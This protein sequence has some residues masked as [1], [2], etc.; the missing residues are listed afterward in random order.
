MAPLH[1]GKNIEK[2]WAEVW[3]CV[4][5]ASMNTRKKTYLLTMQVLLDMGPQQCK[6]RLHR[7]LSEFG[8]VAGLP[9]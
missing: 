9:F 7:Y 4:E 1:P 5:A 8:Q 6:Q 2:L 3:S